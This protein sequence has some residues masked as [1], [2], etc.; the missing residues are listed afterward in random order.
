M[1]TSL[2]PILVGPFRLLFS[3]GSYLA[4]A[5]GL[6]VSGSEFFLSA[7]FGIISNQCGT[8]R[9]GSRKSCR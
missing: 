3:L 8:L 1:L 2:R 4:V 9:T 7:V 6:L 5:L